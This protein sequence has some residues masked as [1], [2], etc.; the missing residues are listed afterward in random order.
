MRLDFEKVQIVWNSSL[1]CHL[2][3]TF[4]FCLKVVASGRVLL[5]HSNVGCLLV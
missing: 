5:R 4:S 2:N 3:S 1:Y